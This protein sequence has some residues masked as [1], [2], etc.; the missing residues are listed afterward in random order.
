MNDFQPGQLVTRTRGGPVMIVK[1]A[2]RR[3]GHPRAEGYRCEWIVE[4]R[5]EEGVFAAEELV[6][7]TGPHSATGPGAS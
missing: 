7:Y 4:G 5:L 6:E 2:V 3:D 1:V